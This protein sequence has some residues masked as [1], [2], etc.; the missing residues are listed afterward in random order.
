MTELLQG[1]ATAVNLQTVHQFDVG[2]SEI[3]DQPLNDEQLDELLKIDPFRE[4]KAENFPRRSPLREILRHETRL[5]RFEKGDLVVRA[6]DYGNS[7]FMVVAGALRVVVDEGLPDSLLGRFKPRRRGIFES[8]AQL[9]RNSRHPESRAPK[10]LRHGENEGD[11]ALGGTRHGGLKNIAK[12]MDEHETV[13]LRRQGDFVGEIAALSRVPRTATV[14]VEKS[15]TVLLEIRWQGLRDLLKFDAALRGYIDEIYR[16]NAL[17]TQMRKVPMF[18][19]LDEERLHKVME[20]TEFST[21]G[22]YQWSGDYK[23]MA[24]SGEVRPEQEPVIV[25]E[26]E[27]ARGIYLIRSGFA[28]LSR[29]YGKGRRTLDYLGT[30]KVHGWDEVV[31]NWRA[32]EAPVSYRHSL[33]AAGYA[34]VLFVPAAVIEEFVLPTHPAETLP[35]PA[36]FAEGRPEEGDSDVR[37]GAGS[38][39]GADMMEF[40]AENRFFNGTAAMVIDLDRCTGCD[41]C[42]RACAAT[43]DNNPRFLRHGPSHGATLIANACMHCVDPVCLIGCPTGAIHRRVGGGQV[44]INQA[45]CIGCSFCAN[46]CPYEAIRMVEVRDQSGAFVVDEEKRPVARAT[47]CDLCVEQPAGPACERACP[48]SALSRIDLTELDDLARWL[49]R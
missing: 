10:E 14:F 5:R 18:E 33:S 11:D 9:W 12:V 35:D 38:R 45:T 49:D 26:G 19:H 23:R 17:S 3:V 20:A 16:R 15:D 1:S 6:G 25:D 29:K 27:F 37:P 30:G 8:I 47:K 4:M 46:N 24:K 44:V 22:N 36:L 41:D 32:P 2:A 31:H 7:A 43:H 48:H 28:R 40:V 39:I 21:F 42:V 34:H 13:T